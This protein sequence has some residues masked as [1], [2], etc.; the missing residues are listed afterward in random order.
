ML[1]LI[2]N[3]HRLNQT[4]ECLIK[5]AQ[6]KNLQVKVVFSDKFDFSVKYDLKKED[7]L[8]RISTDKTSKLVEMHLLNPNVT[9]F[10][11]D[12]QTGLS[13]IDNGIQGYMLHQKLGLPIINLFFVF[14]N[15]NKIFKNM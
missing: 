11:N 6:E 13:R 12:Y 4:Y 5:A 9:T 2:I 7:I 10:Y 3:S 1:Y 15:Q 14:Q 8:Y